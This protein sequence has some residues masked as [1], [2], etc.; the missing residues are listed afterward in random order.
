[1]ISDGLTRFFTLRGA[2]QYAVEIILQILN[3]DLTCIGM[4]ESLCCP[5]EIITT[6]LTGY[7]PI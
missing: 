1:M 4:A 6:W 2:K 5:P 7:T 3:F